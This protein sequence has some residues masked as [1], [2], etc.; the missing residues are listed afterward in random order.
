MERFL[1]AVLVRNELGVLNRITSMFRRRQFNICSLTVS[2]A[3]SSDYSRITL[4]ADGEESAKEQLIN[5]LYKLPDVVSI[6]ELHEHES[7]RRELVLI[8]IKN[9]P[10]TRNDARAAAEAFDATILDYTKD[11]IIYQLTD[12]SRRIDDFID[13]M[14]DFGITEICRTGIVALD[15]GENTIRKVNYL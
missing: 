4:Q 1:L 6:K 11:S 9:D 2:E 13:L 7:V 5:Q 12:D 14:H 10:T 15:R 3:E 8:K